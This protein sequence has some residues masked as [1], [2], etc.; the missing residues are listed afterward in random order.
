MKRIQNVWNF[1][2]L[3]FGGRRDETV[4]EGISDRP[5][6]NVEWHQP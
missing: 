5:L 1:V 4:D 6:V 3:V 2:L